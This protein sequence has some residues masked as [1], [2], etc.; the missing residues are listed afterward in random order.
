MPAG[1][2]GALYSLSG[3]PIPLAVLIGAPALPLAAGAW[4]FAKIEI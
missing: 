2:L 4:R 3:L 1:E